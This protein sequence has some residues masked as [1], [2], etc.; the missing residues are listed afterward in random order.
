MYLIFFYYILN[1]KKHWNKN[2]NNNKK[3]KYHPLVGVEVV[4]ISQLISPMPFP[5]Y[6]FIWLAVPEFLPTKLL[7]LGWILVK[8]LI[9][10]IF[11]VYFRINY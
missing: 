7:Q 10:K 11:I 9:I 3:V 1:F 6:E 5:A 2:F 8:P 4:C